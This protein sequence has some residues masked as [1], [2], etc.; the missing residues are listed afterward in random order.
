M[1]AIGRAL[2]S[3]PKVLLL[4]EPSLGLAPLLVHVIFEVIEEIHEDGTPS[5]SSSRTPTP[6]CAT[7]TGPTCSRPVP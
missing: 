2:M 4:D 6:P 3:R 1:L 7:P 5:F